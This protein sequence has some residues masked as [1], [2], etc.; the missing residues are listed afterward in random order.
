M[1]ARA[2]SATILVIDDVGSELGVPGRQR[3]RS[4]KIIFRQLCRRGNNVDVDRT[5]RAG[6]RYRLRR[7]LLWRRLVGDQGSHCVRVVARTGG[8]RGAQ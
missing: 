6:A 5:N 1:I 7:R 8:P 2:K 4:K 3:S